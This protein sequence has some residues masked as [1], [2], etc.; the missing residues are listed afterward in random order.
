MIVQWPLQWHCM[1]AVWAYKHERKSGDFHTSF[2]VSWWSQVHFF[3]ALWG[4]REK[5]MMKRPQRERTVWFHCNKFQTRVATKTALWTN[6]S[7]LSSP[8]CAFF[9]LHF[10]DQCLLSAAIITHF[11]SWG[12]M[13]LGWK[14]VSVNVLLKNQ[15]IL[16]EAATC[17]RADPL[18]APVLGAAH[19]SV[20]PQWAP[21]GLLVLLQS[22]LKTKG[23][24][25]GV[26]SQSGPCCV[27]Q[28]EQAD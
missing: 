16:R 21:A 6:W 11:G 7:V 1:K 19:R 10:K 4:T 3:K 23:L 15:S 9:T 14:S 24:G 17:T 5:V 26:F 25:G 13:Q 8:I 18:L 22:E 28:T 12:D 27:E 20:N 2:T